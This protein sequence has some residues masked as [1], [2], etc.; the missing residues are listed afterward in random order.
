MKKFSGK[1]LSTVEIDPVSDDYITKIPESVINEMNWY[2]DT[3]LEWVYD[4][5]ILIIREKEDQE[6]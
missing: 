5:D 4:G 3:E 6:E 2:E 1:I